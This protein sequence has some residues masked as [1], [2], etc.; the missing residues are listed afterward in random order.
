MLSTKFGVVAF[1]TALLLA[2]ASYAKELNIGNG[3]VPPTGGGGPNGIGLVGG[4][5]ESDGTLIVGIGTTTNATHPST[6]IYNAVFRRSLSGCVWT[7]TI[8]FGTFS[9][10]T[11]ASS[12]SITG[13]AANNKGLFVQT[14]NQAGTPTDLPFEVHVICG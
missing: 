14:F 5:Y 3:A 10:S 6:G 11:S 8:G 4:S 12:I 7:G 13:L 2:G 1:A 9:G